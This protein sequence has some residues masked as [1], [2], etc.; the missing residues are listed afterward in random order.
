[1][2]NSPLIFSAKEPN[3]SSSPGRI[4]STA[5]ARKA[6]RSKLPVEIHHDDSA[7]AAYRL[8]QHR[9][10]PPAAGLERAEGALC[11]G[12]RS[13]PSA[14]LRGGSTARRTFHTGGDG[15]LLHIS[16]PTRQAEISYAVFCLK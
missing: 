8:A 11:Q 15:S 12:P 13:A 5:S 4:C 6:P 7:T 14:A 3:R 2:N 1:M 16:E 10:T 9:S